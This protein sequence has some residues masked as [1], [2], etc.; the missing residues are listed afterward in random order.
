MPVARLGF[1]A[2]LF[3]VSFVVTAAPSIAD[4]QPTAR[5]LAAEANEVMTSKE[6]GPNFGKADFRVVAPAGG[7]LVGFN[8]GLGPSVGGES[9]FSIRPVFRVPAVGLVPGEEVGNPPRTTAKNAPRSRVTRTVEER[10][11]DGYAVSGWTV[12]AGLWIDAVR[13]SYARVGGAK[14][15]LTDTYTGDWVGGKGGQEAT[16][17]TGGRLAVGIAGKTDLAQVRRIALVHLA[18]PVSTPPPAEVPPPPAP[19]VTPPPAVTVPRVAAAPPGFA[20]PTVGGN[21]PAPGRQYAP[22]RWWNS[23]PKKSILESLCNRPEN[24]SNRLQDKALRLD[25]RFGRNLILYLGFRS[26]AQRLY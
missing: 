8:I 11:K 17:D 2:V 10:A 21:S 5:A 12:R 13:V 16:A 9:V 15:D 20:I 3:A 6:I 14:L 24:G 18:T 4:D 23:I 7:V 1:S 19:M 25:H 26:I 22:P